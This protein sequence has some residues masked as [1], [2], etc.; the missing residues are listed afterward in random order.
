VA[1]LGFTDIAFPKPL[2]H[3]DTLYAESV[4]ADKRLSRTREGEGM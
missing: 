2:F 1:N 4:V 3:G